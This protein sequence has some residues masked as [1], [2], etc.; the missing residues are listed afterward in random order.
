MFDMKCSIMKIYIHIYTE[1]F[2]VWGI[3]NELLEEHW[4][5]VSYVVHRCGF[6]SEINEHQGQRRME[7][8]KEHM[9]K[10][11]IDETGTF[12]SLICFSLSTCVLVLRGCIPL[13]VPLLLTPVDQICNAIE[14]NRTR[15]FCR[16]F[17]Y[18]QLCALKSVSVYY[19][20]G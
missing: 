10:I 6:V 3:F 14:S 1:H 16:G 11:C 18:Y 7:N 8:N 4:F 15:R 12:F 9:C 13:H 2:T 20:N 19:S 5:S 17:C